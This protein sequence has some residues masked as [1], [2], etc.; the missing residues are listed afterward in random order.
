MVHHIGNIINIFKDNAERT[1]FNTGNRFFGTGQNHLFFCVK[2]VIDPAVLQIVCIAEVCGSRY[3][4]PFF[5]K[6]VKA[7]TD[8]FLRPLSLL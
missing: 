5:N 1:L 2:I 8:D 7:Y 6:A 3:R 4:Q